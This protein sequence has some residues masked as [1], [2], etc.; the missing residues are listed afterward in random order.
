MIWVWLYRL[1]VSFVVMGCFAMLFTACFIPYAP[2]M[3]GWR[4]AANQ[5]CVGGL[6]CFGGQCRSSCSDNLDCQRA[7]GESCQINK[8]CCAPS[9][10]ICNGK[11]DDCNG[12]I[13]DGASCATGTCQNGVCE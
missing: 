11:D 4:C 1:V 10:E 5:D 12:I 8:F 9:Q 2:E 7:L 13:D 6:K 3:R